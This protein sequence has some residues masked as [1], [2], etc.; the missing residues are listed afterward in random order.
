MKS[1]RSVL[2]FT[3]KLRAFA[4]RAYNLTFANPRTKL[5]LGVERPRVSDKGYAAARFFAQAKKEFKWL[6]LNRSVLR[7]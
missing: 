6:T 7:K 5:W 3:F 1:M 4:A 2:G